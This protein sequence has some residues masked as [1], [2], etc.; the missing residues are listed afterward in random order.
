MARFLDIVIENWKLTP[1]LPT[2]RLFL[3]HKLK[4]EWTSSKAEGV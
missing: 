2:A 1:T 4:D 3:I